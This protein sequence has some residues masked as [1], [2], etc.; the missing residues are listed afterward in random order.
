MSDYLKHLNEIDSV[1]SYCPKNSPHM[2][3]RIKM[4]AKI[5][6][7]YDVNHHVLQDL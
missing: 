4:V 2:E 1:I 3:S 5:L 7:K 6:A